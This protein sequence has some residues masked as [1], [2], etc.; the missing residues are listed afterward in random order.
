MLNNFYQ[1][2]QSAM[3]TFRSTLDPQAFMWTRTLRGEHDHIVQ[4][5]QKS[6]QARKMKRSKVLVA[7]NAPSPEE[8]ET[9]ETTSQTPSQTDSPLQSPRLGK[10]TKEVQ[11]AKKLLKILN[12][13]HM[14]SDVESDEGEKETKS[15]AK[16]VGKASKA[17]STS[18]RYNVP[19][20]LGS[21]LDDEEYG[22]RERKE[23]AKKDSQKLTDTIA[24]KKR[25][26]QKRISLSNVVGA[27]VDDIEDD[28]GNSPLWSSANQR[29][30]SRVLQEKPKGSRFKNVTIARQHVVRE[31]EKEDDDTGVIQWRYKSFPGRGQNGSIVKRISD[32]SEEF[33]RGLFSTTDDI[34]SLKNMILSMKED[35]AGEIL[36]L[37]ETLEQHTRQIG[38]LNKTNSK[39][40]LKVENLEK[41]MKLLSA[42]QFV[43]ASVP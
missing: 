17:R 16:A 5:V 36:E 23:E 10:V 41:E 43:S 32:P 14:V 24:S 18:G 31:S 15:P 7:E 9:D 22:E 11:Q 6:L 28:N 35:H 34:E 1:D 3:S 12:L 30:F 8:E 37:T 38:L 21:D 29:S 4:K 25:G 19:T 26:A 2:R 13:D 33:D 42:M 39:L 40:L 27:E 20:L